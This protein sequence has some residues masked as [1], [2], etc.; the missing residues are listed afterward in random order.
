MKSLF[1]IFA[2][3]I[4]A[5]VLS[6]GIT[7]GTSLYYVG[8]GGS[9]ANSGKTWALR[10]ASISKVNST[11]GSE[12]T[13]D[14][15]LVAAGTYTTT[16]N[17]SYAG[18]SRTT[19]LV[20]MNY[21]TDRPVID[22]DG[23]YAAS[24]WE[25]TSADSNQV[26]QGFKIESDSFIYW[27]GCVGLVIK[28][29][30]AVHPA[31][32]EI[33]EQGKMEYSSWCIVDQCTTNTTP[34]GTSPWLPNP[35]NDGEE[36]N[37]LSI[38]YDSHHILVQNCRL[39][40]EITHYQQSTYGGTSVS[41]LIYR[42]NESWR[43]HGP[44]DGGA[45]GVH[46]M[47]FDNIVYRRNYSSWTSQN[48]KGMTWQTLGCENTIW[49]YCRVLKDTNGYNVNRTVLAGGVNDSLHTWKT[50]AAYNN[51]LIGMYH[52]DD[53]YSDRGLMM[54]F[55]QYHNYTENWPYME[56]LHFKNNIFCRSNGFMLF[57]SDHG[58]TDIDGHDIVF[59]NNLWYDATAGDY[60]KIELQWYGNGTGL[61][62]MSTAQSSYPTM[63]YDNIEQAPRFV[64][65]ANFDL[66]LQSGSPAIDAGTHLTI[67]NDVGGGSGTS[68]V[69][70]NA[71]YFCDGW[72]MVEGD[73]IKIGSTDPVGI[74]SISGNTITLEASRT[75][76]DND[77]VYYYRYDRWKGSAP[78]IG[79]MEYD[80]GE[81]PGWGPFNK[82]WA[83][84]GSQMVRWKTFYNAARDADSNRVFSG[85]SIHIQSLKNDQ[86]SFQLVIEGG[87][88]ATDSINV[89][90]DYLNDGTNW[91]INTSSACSTFVGRY[92]EPFMVW[93]N[94][95]DTRATSIYWDN[96]YPLPDSLYLGWVPN[97]LV[98]L[99]VNRKLLSQGG[100]DTL[101]YGAGGRSG[102]G[103][104]VFP[105][106][107]TTIWF[108]IFVPKTTPAG[109]YRGEVK[110]VKT[111]R[112]DTLFRIPIDLKVRN[113]A[114]SDTMHMPYFAYIN[115]SSLAGRGQVTVG[116]TYYN[117]TW[118]P[119]LQYWAK[120]HRF[121]I[122]LGGET[123][124]DFMDHRM[125]FYSG[126]RYTK[127]QGYEGIGEGKGNNVYIAG[128]YNCN[129]RTWHADGYGVDALGDYPDTPTGWRRL[130]DQ[131]EQAFLDSAASTIRAVEL[132]DEALHHDV[133][134]LY[135]YGEQRLSMDTVSTWIRTGTGVGKNLR[136]FIPN[137][138][139]DPWTV[140]HIP[141]S[142]WHGAASMY[143]Q[144]PNAF[145]WGYGYNTDRYN[146]RYG[147]DPWTVEEVRERG[148]ADPRPTLIGTY[149][150]GAGFMPNFQGVD[151]PL[152]YP[153]L[154]F[155]VCWEYQV[156]FLLRWS[157]NEW[158][159]WPEDNPFIRLFP[160]FSE[161]QD[162]V[163]IAY[164]ED[165]QY[166]EYAMGLQMP[167]TSVSIKAM[168]DGLRDYEMLY[169]A[170]RRG[171]LDTNWINRTGVWAAF[172]DYRYAQ[173]QENGFPSWAI[174]GYLLEGLR[175]E[176]AVAL[177]SVGQGETEV[178]T[179]KKLRG[180]RLF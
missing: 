3:L 43:S 90:L 37:G 132:I 172:N 35:P 59:G 128:L 17:L 72:G 12:S 40:G 49:R 60:A 27:N 58:S 8:S 113:Y 5:T 34:L 44:S 75:W 118:M 67:V 120:R 101:Q 61:I 144:G 133:D 14:T 117:E 177:E 69:V 137:G 45:G 125:G 96:P 112:A 18:A 39:M 130:S 167:I 165:K 10:W 13:Y 91:I 156:D 143:C 119:R 153:R 104:K 33:Y 46:H 86:V 2:L 173:H 76:G 32:S 107:N 162:G 68:L 111:S 135:T 180:K 142:G 139:F 174:N 116:S 38:N 77:P 52:Y 100:G 70:D 88:T 140:E 129:F 42:D 23:G 122:A 105:L 136:T 138:W 155:W 94:Y 83:V 157:L 159:P 65:S 73:S 154:S 163:G 168:R 36:K 31:I 20:V 147:H 55:E 26:L 146:P 50:F 6:Q 79:A 124:V 164:G 121:D 74:T 99:E 126:W 47:L 64:D 103:F 9:D 97:F 7:N 131:F 54:F 57:Y 78:D 102:P 11:L 41:Y 160:G 87:V 161:S 24:G 48:G 16:L 106:R 108:D 84:D 15:V 53:G 145:S 25:G 93:Y 98:P 115:A 85:D 171:V 150:S 179:I 62:S 22:V 123:Y 141:A 176:M 109:T 81:P 80:S 178:S 4:P 21:G 95:C 151:M 149:H 28:N 82:V 110:I 148:A 158:C 92:I 134:T 30:Y 66:R 56:T 170:N 166:P 89:M 114:L 175:R 29:C 127:A 152:T 71:M 19:R 169:E 1:L 51:T 63:F